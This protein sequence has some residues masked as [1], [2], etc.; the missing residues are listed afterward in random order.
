MAQDSTKKR[1]PL[2]Q[3]AYPDDLRKREEALL[4]RRPENTK[5]DPDERLAKIG[6]ALSGGG[7]RSGT[8]AFGVIQALAARNVLREIDVLSTVSGGGYTGSLIS[9]LYA[10]TEVERAKDVEQAIQPEGEAQN[11][12]GWIGSGAVLRWL[13]EN[14]RYMAPNGSGDLLLAGAIILRNWLSIHV[15][16][17]TLVL[18]A[19][20]LMQL[21]RNGLHAA[22]SGQLDP[23][24]LACF[25]GAGPDGSMSMA[26]LEARLTCYLP[27]GES[28]LWWSPWLL[29]PLLIFVFWMVPFGWAYWLASDYDEN[30]SFPQTTLTR[31][32]V[33]LYFLLLAWLLVY[34]VLLAEGVPRSVSVAGGAVLVTGLITMCILFYVVKASRFRNED[35][36]LDD[37]QLR[38]WL[39]SKLKTALTWFGAALS[40][41]VIDT[42]GQTV[43]VV[44]QNPEFSLGGWLGALL[45]GLIAVAAGARQIATY[46][47]GKA[48][49]TRIRPSLNIV[50]MIVAVLLVTGTLT[51]LNAFSHG[52]AWGF[53]YPY[54][55][56]EKLV[57]A[58]GPPRATAV[59]SMQVCA[60][61]ALPCSDSAKL[62]RLLC[63]DCA[64]PGER[65]F[66]V[67]AVVLLFLVVVSLLFGQ[68]WP[69][70]NNSTLLPLYTARL[71]R[72]YLGASNRHRIAPHCPAPVA[73]T[74]VHECD[75]MSIE[76][77]WWPRDKQDG[78]QDADPFAKG[79][80]LHLVNVTI[81]ET[82]S[83]VSRVQQNDRK[84]VGM[85]VGPA[86]I[87]AGVR[88]HVVFQGWANS[89]RGRPAIV[90]PE[91]T[92][93][94]Q[95][96]RMFAYS[97]DGTAPNYTG[98]SLTLGQ[99]TGI[100]GAAFSTG[101]GSRTSLGLSLIAGFFNVR[102]GLWWDSGVEPTNRCG[103]ATK[104]SR[105]SERFF[106]W[107]LPVQ[108]F[109]VDEFL[110]R[111]PGVARRWWYL[112]D[113]GHFENTGAYE[114]IRRRLPL[115][116]IVD[117]GADPDYEYEDLANLTRKARLDFGA[118]IEFLDDKALRWM[119][120][121][122]R[123]M[124]C[125]AHFGSL[126]VL[127]RGPS[128]AALAWVRYIDEPDRKSLIV[129]L[130]PT[131]V[132][133]EPPDITSYHATHPVFPQ[134]TTADLFFDEAQWESY[135]KLGH[136]ITERVF[137]DGFEPYFGLLNSRS[138]VPRD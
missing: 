14:G 74:Q 33:C 50:A 94:C 49:A 117:A 76:D 37:P 1:S 26:G 6:L 106:S 90:F 120:R 36:A 119:R 125:L 105:Q 42:L 62:A 54:H 100:S 55:V 103:T 109:L 132:G 93:E 128:R 13:R 67:T 124:E 20:A 137:A 71:T 53:K 84:G 4:R 38:H 66:G 2:W 29:L 32:C 72:A 133:D 80:P 11:A 87:S 79:A 40:L 110:S 95:P 89:E 5:K 45:G 59:T 88:H 98:R 28:Y 114:L 99:W 134:Q 129:Y 135:R 70:L 12:K 46:F 8:F 35:G 52:I 111:F 97:I 116:V 104:G 60:P 31:F 27:L 78:G 121:N 7:I 118:E 112:S 127:R 113:G 61:D 58:P 122:R 123:N 108:S 102:L 17:A 39:S 56:P 30:T 22:L 25:A 24:I 115:I 85:A 9:R 15:V 10:R 86:G 48:G 131:L 51:A 107:L 64:A 65:N 130:K 126:E 82:L 21:V 23:A 81:N 77:R 3:Q 41:A 19:F 96:F 73:V 16:L 75:D 44:W 57:A 92:P 138:P 136:F 91:T 47:P 83:G 63:M 43:Y 34:A 68:S 18:A 69:F 101:L